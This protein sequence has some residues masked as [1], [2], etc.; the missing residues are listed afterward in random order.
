[1]REVTWARMWDLYPAP[2]VQPTNRGVLG[3]CP[4]TSFYRQGVK[5]LSESV[6]AGFEWEPDVSPGGGS[7]RGGGASGWRSSASQVAGADS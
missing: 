2:A 1:M 6:C 7:E 3:F 4:Q 5:H